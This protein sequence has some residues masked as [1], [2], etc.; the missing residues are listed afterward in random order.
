MIVYI[1]KM[2]QTQNCIWYH[3]CSDSYSILGCAFPW[4]MKLS[5]L[6]YGFEEFVQC[7]F[8]FHFRSLF[9]LLLF[10]NLW[11]ILFNCFCFFF[12][13]YYWNALWIT[14]HFHIYIIENCYSWYCLYIHV[15]ILITNWQRIVFIFCQIDNA[16]TSRSRLLKQYFIDHFLNFSNAT[17]V[18]DTHVF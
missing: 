7:H 10:D 15:Y 6:F 16:Q 13:C 18:Q 1:L 8:F 4:Q 5:W 14:F 17:D 11:T 9:L 3:S 2:L 12:F